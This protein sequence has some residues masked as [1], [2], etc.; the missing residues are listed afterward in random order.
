MI[1]IS[2]AVSEG[3]SIPYE[4]SGKCISR[5]FVDQPFAT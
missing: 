4:D 1:G 2:S 5:D 3:V